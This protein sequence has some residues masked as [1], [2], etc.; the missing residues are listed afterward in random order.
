MRP[1]FYQEKGHMQSSNLFSSTD[2]KTDPFLIALANAGILQCEQ[3]SNIVYEAQIKKL[4]VFS[5]LIQQQQIDANTIAQQLATYLGLEFFDL[6][7]LTHDA[8]IKDVID[9]TFICQRGVLP[10]FIQNQKLY[11]AISDSLH[12]DHIGEIKFHTDLNIYPVVV[13]WNKLARMIDIFLSDSP[14]YITQFSNQSANNENDDHVI[15]LTNQLLQDAVHKNASD[16]HIEPYK[17]AYRIRFRLDGILHKITQLPLDIG[18]RISARLKVISHLDMAERRLPQDGRFILETNAKA[19]KDCRISVCP[20]LFGEKVVIRI[21]DA[22]KVSLNIDDLGFEVAQKKVFLNA[23]QKPQGMILVTGPTGSGKTITLY[24]ALRLLNKL[25]KNI[26]T[27]E[28][29]VEITLPGINQINVDPKIELTFEKVLRTFLRQDPDILMVGEIRDQKTADI[30]IKAAQTGHLVLSTL[31]TNS[32]V[33]TLTRLF[34]L[35]IS[36]FNVAHSVQL[37]I[38]QRLVRKLCVYCKRQKENFL[39]MLVY[40]AVGCEHCMKGYLGRVAVFECLPISPEISAM[41]MQERSNAD[42]TATAKDFGMI[43]LQEA[44]LNKVVEGITSLE[45]IQR[46]I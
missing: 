21:L 1:S 26:C 16:I 45:E 40:E 27:V 3:I 35:G 4:S 44:A 6:D 36:K 39:E 10:L 33:E 42:I 28:E 20:T 34:M 38:A 30:A 23:I 13:A 43:S 12:L 31:H 17:T 24:T 11:L 18:T 25:E 2:L 22:E 46:V 29:P 5:V 37:V 9:E 7:Q 15:S 8:I 32:A 19:S 41:I 14:Y